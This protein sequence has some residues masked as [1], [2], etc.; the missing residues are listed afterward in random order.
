MLVFVICILWQS[1]EHRVLSRDPSTDL[2]YKQPD[3]GLSSPNTTMPPTSQTAHFDIGSPSSSLSNYDSANSSQSSTGEKRSSLTASRGPH[4]QLNTAHT[5]LLLILI[6]SKWCPILFLNFNFKG[7]WVQ[8]LSFFLYQLTIR[9][10]D[11][12]FLYMLN[13]ASQPW[14]NNQL[15]TEVELTSCISLLPFVRY[16]RCIVY[17]CCT[18]VVC[19]Q[20]VFVLD[21]EVGDH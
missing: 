13:V 9:I 19:V 18:L 7:R 3:S 14:W 5:G 20:I 6:H 4:T 17:W 10:L 8:Q 11:C 2:E 12:C 15:L 1:V 16:H 21:G